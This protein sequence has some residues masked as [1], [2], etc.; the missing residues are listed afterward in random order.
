M[1]IKETP[2]QG[3]FSLRFSLISLILPIAYKKFDNEQHVN[4][5]HSLI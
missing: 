1:L 5:D 3:H 2:P 4:Q